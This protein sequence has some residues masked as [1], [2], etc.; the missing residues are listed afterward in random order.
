VCDFSLQ[1]LIELLFSAGMKDTVVTDPIKFQQQGG[2]ELA[3][4]ST[5]ENKVHTP[6]GLMPT[7]KVTWF[8]QFAVVWGNLTRALF[9]QYI[10]FPF[11]HGL[12]PAHTLPQ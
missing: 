4:M 8:D 3:P 12:S 5:T 6:C 10:F 2:T 1:L 9:T 7:R 11:K